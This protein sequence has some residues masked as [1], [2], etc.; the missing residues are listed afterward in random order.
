MESLNKENIDNVSGAFI[1][2]VQ[3]ALVSYF[4]LIYNHSIDIYSTSL[5][6]MQLKKH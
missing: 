6:F 4:L 1:K 5:Q 2:K 3:D